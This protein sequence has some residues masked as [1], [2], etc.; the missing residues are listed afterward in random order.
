MHERQPVADLIFDLLIGQ[1]VKRLQHQNLEHHDGIE[2]LAAGI[3]L[4]LLGRQ[5]DYCLDLGA[6]TL[7]GNDC[8][9]YLER[10]TLGTDCLKTS[11]EIE[12]A[13]LPHRIPLRCRCRDT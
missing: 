8:L 7:E 3:A 11:V 2:G 1:I 4:P 9:E 5:P 6:E 10:I 13:R 12:K